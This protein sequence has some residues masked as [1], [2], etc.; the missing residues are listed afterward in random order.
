MGSPVE[1][2][3]SVQ[4]VTEFGAVIRDVFIFR[5]EGGNTFGATQLLKKSVVRQLPPEI[6]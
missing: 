2:E 3:V 5:Y 4:Q 6:G 1:R